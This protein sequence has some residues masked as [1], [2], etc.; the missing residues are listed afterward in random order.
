MIYRNHH[1][2]YDD[3]V[4]KNLFIIIIKDENSCAA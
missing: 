4:L 1:I 3:L 2:L